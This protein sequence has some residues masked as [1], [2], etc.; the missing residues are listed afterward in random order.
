MSDVLQAFVAQGGKL[1][2]HEY[3]TEPRISVGSGDDADLF[4]D[5]EGVQATHLW[6]ERKGKRV[7]LTVEGDASVKVAGEDV[8]TA[9]LRGF[10]DVVVGPYTLKF[11]VV[12][13]GAGAEAAQGPEATPGA[14][15]PVESTVGSGEAPVP[16]PVP[17]PVHEPAAESDPAPQPGPDPPIDAETAAL[18][19]PDTATDP[20]LQAVAFPPEAARWEPEPMLE[21]FWEQREDDEDEGEDDHQ[22]PAFSLVAK[23]VEEHAAEALAPGADVDLAL[24]VM[25]ILD[26]GVEAQRTLRPGGEVRGRAGGLVAHWPQEG[27]PAGPDGDPLSVGQAVDVDVDGQRWRIRLALAPAPPPGVAGPGVSKNAAAVTFASVALHALVIG[28]AAVLLP[29]EEMAETLDVDRFAQVQ[30]IDPAEEVEKEQEDE[31]KE[32]EEEDNPE[33]DEVAPADEAP[34]PK[35]KKKRKKKSKF[36]GGGGV[37]GALSRFSKRKG[38]KT[39]V[40]AMVA[41]ITG[42]TGAK[43][44]KGFSVSQLG[45]GVGGKLVAG[46]QAGGA[47]M[48]TGTR[49]IDDLFAG[50]KRSMGGRKK[51]KV[52]GTVRKANRRQIRSKGSGTLD[53]AAIAKVVG[54]NIGQVRYCYERTLLKSPNLRG[55]V[56][57][58]WT[59]APSGK[60]RSASTQFS[61]VT[62]DSLTRCILGK[63]K[64]WKFPKPKGG[65]VIVSYPFIFN[66]VGF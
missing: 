1:L 3:F 63:I 46:G 32:E 27:P 37:L 58:Q 9:R 53:K 35:V 42:V 65:Q 62:S 51:A 31:K 6:I 45:Q 5:E 47:G 56:V 55:K 64:K 11:K 59:I 19:S 34:P 28:G 60:V 66:S 50:K 30:I 43:G 39:S 21:A 22:P 38:G 7:V 40:A 25:R 4:L 23:V 18:I 10:D 13:A 8:R 15:S 16:E 20:N 26:E 57:V 2:G 33:A 17:E 12:K 29:T 44:A 52:R 14:D 49:G 36:A 54:K 48:R 61:S 24:E 41:G